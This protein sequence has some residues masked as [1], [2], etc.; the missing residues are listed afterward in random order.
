MACDLS[1]GVAVANSIGVA[2]AGGLLFASG[3]L[4]CGVSSSRVGG[5]TSFTFVLG[6]LGVQVELLDGNILIFGMGKAGF[7]FDI[8]LTTAQRCTT[9][10]G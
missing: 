2:V 8:R 6:D 9:K 3:L 4:A 1:I 10:S 7:I 5:P